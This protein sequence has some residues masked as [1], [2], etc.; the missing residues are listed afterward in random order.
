[1]CI[2]VLFKIELL[3]S[4]WNTLHWIFVVIPASYSC[5]I[6]GCPFTCIECAHMFISTGIPHIPVE[7]KIIY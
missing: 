4:V 2:M 5:G 6:Q 3:S 1:M 7:N